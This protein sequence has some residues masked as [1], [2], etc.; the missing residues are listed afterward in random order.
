LGGGYGGGI[1]TA[2]AHQDFFASYGDDDDSADAYSWREE[3]EA[4]NRYMR[5][6]MAKK[7]EI[8]GVGGSDRAAAAAAEAQAGA[9]LRTQALD[10]C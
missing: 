9:P 8:P 10:R 7:R 6:G 5:E 2:E 1:S 3:E 4:Y